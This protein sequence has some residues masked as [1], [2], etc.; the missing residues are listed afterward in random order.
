MWIS[1]SHVSK[2]NITSGQWIE[3]NMVQNWLFINIL[4][5]YVDHWVIERFPKVFTHIKSVPSDC[6]FVLCFSTCKI[7]KHPEQ[8]PN[9]PVRLSTKPLDVRVNKSFCIPRSKYFFKSPLS[10]KL[11][12]VFF[13]KVKFRRNNSWKSCWPKNNFLAAYLMSL[14]SWWKP[15]ALWTTIMWVI[16]L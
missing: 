14:N 1:T 5:Y 11:L 4:F 3:I 10:R 2:S 13:K 15:A 16:K 7:S 8:F 12:S 6:F 9:G